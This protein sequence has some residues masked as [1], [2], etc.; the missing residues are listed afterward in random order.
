MSRNSLNSQT[1]K[2]SSGQNKFVRKNGHTVN[3]AMRFHTTRIYRLHDVHTKLVC[4][5]S[6]IRKGRKDAQILGALYHPKKGICKH[7]L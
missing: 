7:N 1:K 2:M 3:S 5:L 4:G 6:S